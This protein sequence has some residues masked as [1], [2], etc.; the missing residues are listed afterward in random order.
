M[1][2]TF[3][4]CQRREL[5]SSNMLWSVVWSLEVSKTYYGWLFSW[6]LLEC[7]S[8]SP[9]HH[10][11]LKSSFVILVTYLFIF[12]I[13]SSFP[14][15]KH[16]FDYPASFCSA[17]KIVG[18]NEYRRFSA[19]RTCKKL[20]EKDEHLQSNA[21]QKILWKN[22]AQ[23]IQYKLFF[24]LKQKGKKKKSKTTKNFNLMILQHFTTH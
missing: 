10:F 23:Y 8:S 17:I 7:W 12:T 3:S 13:S 14:F 16:T 2:K 18:K 9:C 4:K 6:R 1:R 15:F 22:P 20:S 24:L 11:K 21:A 19:Q 5:E